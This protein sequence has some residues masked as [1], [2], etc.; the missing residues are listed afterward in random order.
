MLA[1]S[2]GVAGQQS[3]GVS[4][5]DRGVAIGMV[6]QWSSPKSS[7]G[8]FAKRLHDKDQSVCAGMLASTHVALHTLLTKEGAQAK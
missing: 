6:A 3:D 4:G 8:G 1:I 2:A 5:Q 7:A